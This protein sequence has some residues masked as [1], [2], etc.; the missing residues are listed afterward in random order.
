MYNRNKHAFP[1]I[2]S[3][4]LVN[5]FSHEILKKVGS[6]EYLGVHKIRN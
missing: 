4:A 1:E 5:T 2:V 6:D 3:I